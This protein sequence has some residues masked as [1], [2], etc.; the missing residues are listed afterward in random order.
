MGNIATKSSKE[1]KMSKIK[2][3]KFDISKVSIG[4]MI[5]VNVWRKEFS[6]LSVSAILKIYATKFNVERHNMHKHSFSHCVDTLRKLED[7]D[8]ISPQNKY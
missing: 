3:R 8:Y 4:R 1:N 5:E 6:D 7:P 2:K